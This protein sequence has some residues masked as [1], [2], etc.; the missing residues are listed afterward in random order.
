MAVGYSHHKVIYGLGNQTIKTV[1]LN[2]Y[3][4]PTAISSCTYR[5]VDLRKDEDDAERILVAAGTNATID[6]T[7]TTT[8][9][10]CGKG[11]PN[12]R[13]IPVQSIV[14][15]V[16]GKAY[17]LQAT[18]GERELI[19]AENIGSN[20][21]TP[22]DEITRRYASGS[23]LK[24]IEVSGTFPT[25]IAND[26]DKVEDGEGGPFAIDWSWDL[27][28][29]SRREIIWL[30]R[31]FDNFLCTSEE[32]FNLDS[33][34]AAVSGNRVKV[35][36][37]I[38]QS[39]MEIRAHIQA[40]GLSPEDFHGNDLLKLAVIYRTAWHLSN[41]QKGDKNESRAAEFKEESQKYLDNLMIGK[42]PEKTV[43]TNLSNDTATGGGSKL[44]SHWQNLS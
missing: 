4:R 32:V 25:L 10:I 23:T 33:S 35:E 1:P 29:P 2:D 31:Q 22:K 27:T 16:A 43:K 30:V 24:G 44:Y 17:L 19:I 36:S 15:F 38:R 28:P 3:G 41:Q 40:H 14:G 5:I 21:I 6:T 13:K 12:T 37:A 42:F 7:T 8:S 20:Y 9:A 11:T 26:I 39:S 34:F 18:D